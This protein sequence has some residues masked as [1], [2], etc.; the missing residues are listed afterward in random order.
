MSCIERY[1]PLNEPTVIRWIGQ[2]EI[3]KPERADGG[4][5]GGLTLILL[6]VLIRG[7]K[8][9]LDSIERGYSRLGLQTTSGGSGKV[10]IERRRRR[11]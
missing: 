5:E 3:S 9:D 8:E 10:S 1:I 6:E 7:L 4:R 11:G 2:N